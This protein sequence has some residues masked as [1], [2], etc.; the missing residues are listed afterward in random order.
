[1][2]QKIAYI[3]IDERTD[4]RKIALIIASILCFILGIIGLLIPVIPQIPF[5]ILGVLCLS[6]A[7]TRF[8]RFLIGT[9]FY[10]KYLKKHVEKHEKISEFLNE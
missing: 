7:S 2:N 3:F 10:Q 8:K 6:A 9:S 1:M 4:M 5:F